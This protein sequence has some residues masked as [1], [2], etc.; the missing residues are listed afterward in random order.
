MH[1]TYWKNLLTTN[2]RFNAVIAYGWAHCRPYLEL[3]AVLS[4]LSSDV[5]SIF[6]EYLLLLKYYCIFVKVLLYF[7]F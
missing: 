1:S 3:K 4:K 6:P 5:V 7:R 2:I